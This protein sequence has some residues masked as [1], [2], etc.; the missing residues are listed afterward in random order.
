MTISVLHIVQ[1]LA[2]GGLETLVLE[3][4]ARDPNCHV[5][6]LDGDADSALAAWPRLA[7]HADRL[8]FLNKPPGI[9]LDTIL[10]LRALISR[11]RPIAIHTHH[12]GPM[13]YG[14]LATRFAGSGARWVHTEHDAWHLESAKRAALVRGI[15]MLLRPQMVSDADAVAEQLQQRCG[16]GSTTIRNGIDTAKFSPIEKD[17]ARATF[18]LPPDKILIGTAGRMEPVKNQALLLEAFAGIEH[19]VDAM[20][21][22]AGDGSQRTALEAKAALLGLGKRVRFLGRVDRMPEYLSALDVFVL[23]SDKEGYPLSLLEAQACGVPVIATDVGGSRDAVCPTTGAL[24][25]AKDRKGLTA[26]LRAFRAPIQTPR[27]F[28]LAEGSIDAMAA[29]YARI[30]GG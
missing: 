14:G 8:H 28:V 22:L 13:L 23:P 16:I 7:D 19:S 29:D 5:A 10:A 20:L 26:L 2:P 24:F 6:S 11:L 30:Y 18:D 3:M 4:Q 15:A 25:Q 9:R 1:H 17:V 27:D 12:I 21:V